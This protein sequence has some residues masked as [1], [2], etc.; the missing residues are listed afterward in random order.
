VGGDGGLAAARS[1]PAAQREEAAKPRRAPFRAKRRELQRRS[2]AAAAGV[3]ARARGQDSSGTPGSGPKAGEQ[4][5][6][7][8]TRRTRGEARG[9]DR[10]KGELEAQRVEARREAAGRAARPRGVALGPR[11]QRGAMGLHSDATTGER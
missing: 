8:A 9:L 4:T 10:H 5:E 3:S 2:W 11:G 7:R 6:L 1:A